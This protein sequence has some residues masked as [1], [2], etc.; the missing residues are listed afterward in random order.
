M[1]AC[2][3][4]YPTKF[5]ILD[6]PLESPFQRFGCRMC[7]GVPSFINHIDLGKNM[8]GASFYLHLI[9]QMFKGRVLQ[10]RLKVKCAT[11][12]RV[13]DGRTE[14]L[15]AVSLATLGGKDLF[16]EFYNLLREAFQ[17]KN[18]FSWV[19]PKMGGPLAQIDF[20]TFLDL[21]R[22]P[23]LACRGGPHCPNWFWFDTFIT[24]KKLPKRD[25]FG[26]A[27]ATWL[28]LGGVI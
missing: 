12:S 3:S 28:Q 13:S 11:N 19:F 9:N 7:P 14:Q 21:K 26:R 18:P 5:P 8:W 22:L 23:K 25:P 10:V 20:D 24:L 17:E 27:C 1:F 2:L 16:K 15:G 4:V 6:S